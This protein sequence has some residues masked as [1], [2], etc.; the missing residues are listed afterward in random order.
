[1]VHWEVHTVALR[2][3][4]CTYMWCVTDA[5]G[6]CTH[7]RCTCAH[8]CVG[9]TCIGRLHV[10]APLRAHAWCLWC[11]SCIGRVRMRAQQHELH[12]AAFHAM[13][14]STWLPVHVTLFACCNSLL[15]PYS[16]SSQLDAVV[17]HSAYSGCP[18][19]W[20]AVKVQPSSSIGGQQSSRA[21][22][23]HLAGI[24]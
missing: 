21:S 20:R 8:A 14:F 1:M 3:P 18:R 11:V 16:P 13:S 4:L 15:V 5:L 2:A 24:E 6:G 19:F 12:C 22:N 7:L 9:V 23:V 10:P 17:A